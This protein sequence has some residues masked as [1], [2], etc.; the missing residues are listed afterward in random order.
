MSH[1]ASAGIRPG[2]LSSAPET[3]LG[4][5]RQPSIIKRCR[6][7][8]LVRP[9]GPVAP[10]QASSPPPSTAPVVDKV[11]ALIEGT[12]SGDNLGSEDR[13]EVDACLQQLDD[14]GEARDQRPLEDPLVFG[15]YNVAYVSAGP[16][17]SGQPAGGR[18]RGGLGKLLFRTTFLGQ[19]VLQPDI[20]TNK[21]AFRLLGFLPGAV[22]LRGKFVSIPER[23]GGP[24]RKDTVKVFFEPPVLSLPGGIHIR[25]GPSSSVVL[26]TTYVDE[27]V[28]LGKGSRG[29][30]FVFTRG[31]QADAE[32][33]DQV[34]LQQ[35]SG[36]GKAVLFGVVA[37]LMLNG[38][39][40][41]LQGSLPPVVRAAGVV[42]VLLGTALGG[43]CYKGGIVDDD[44]EERPEVTAGGEEAA[45]S[46]S[47][48]SAV[49]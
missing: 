7:L 25:I 33:M 15:N 36:L 27:R 2:R 22:G 10:L 29:S 43:I 45:A 41:A 13:R 14:I 37:L 40:L 39:W 21:L 42:Q 26:K 38:S 30:L 46:A 47:G 20:V 23:E 12:D 31:G 9:A 5:S 8:S 44:S 1:T 48:G 18:F 4:A 3:A 17:Q 32:G 11:L 49:A 6:R 19:S 24:N 34:G 35:C 28:R 16:G